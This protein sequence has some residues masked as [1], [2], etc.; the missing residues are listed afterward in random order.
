MKKELAKILAVAAIAPTLMGGALTTKALAYDD[1]PPTAWYAQAVQSMEKILPG[2]S[3]EVFAPSATVAAGDF[4]SALWRLANPGSELTDK[5][6]AMLWANSMGIFPAGTSREQGLKRQDAAT[7][8]DAFIRNAA[9][10]LPAT[11]N[12][13]PE[14]TDQEQ[15]KEE[16]IPAVQ[17]MQTTGL[18]K[19]FEDGS[20]R[21]Q[22]P[23]RR[24]EAATILE[25]LAPACENLPLVIELVGNPSTGYSWTLEAYDE[26]IV[27]VSPLEY[28]SDPAEEGMV[29]VPG[30]Y[31]FAVYGLKEGRATVDF[32]YMRANDKKED[33]ADEQHMSFAVDAE[34]RVWRVDR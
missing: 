27:Q 32:Y 17:L 2:L 34:G 20:F 14:F 16:A 29:G 30:K 5:E 19:G 18:M 28:V 3:G 10:N 33:A 6:T 7:C 15:I 25:K 13:P 31:R 24:S 11:L 26:S 22:Q 23:L 12:I 9:V 21:P 4:A 8:L 1:V